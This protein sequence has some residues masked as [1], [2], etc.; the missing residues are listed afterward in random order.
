MSNVSIA[1]DGQRTD[2]LRPALV[3][4]ALGVVFGDI[5]TSPLYAFRESLHAAGGVSHDTVLGLLSLIF[6]AIT[7]V[8]S[9]KY[10]SLVLL[11]DN[12][13][14][15]GILALLAGVL[16]QVPRD[17]R[18]R[19]AAIFAGLAGAAMFYGDSVI[20]PAISVLSAVEG[21]E[22]VSPQFKSLVVPLTLAILVAL[23][24]AQRLGT[25]SM[26]RWFG[27]VM[28][29]W[30]GSLA[31]LGLL[32]IARN[33]QVLQAL[34]P[35][36]AIA[37]AAEN[38]QLMLAVLGAVFLA[39]TGGEALYADLGH[40]GRRPIRLAWF[41]IVMPALALNYFGQGAL[42]LADPKAIENPFFML[43]PE[44]LQLPL[45]VLAAAATVIASQA[46]IS[47]A[48]SLTAQ[49]V[50]LGYIPRVAVRFTSQTSAGQIFVPLV[51]WAL[52]A[53]VIALVLAF[54]SSS[55]LAAAYGIAVSTTMVITTLG[56]M[57][58]AARRWG[59][60]PS[61][62]WLVC[63]PLLVLD[64]AFTVANL[65]KVNDGGW[66]P[67]VFGGVLMLLF[68]TWVRGRELLGAALTRTGLQMQPFLQSLSTY[69]PQ[70]VE[71]TAVFMTPTVDMIPHSL[72]HNLKHNRVLHERVL[73]LTAEAENAPH[74]PPAAMVQLRDLGDGCWYARVRLG[75]QDAH[76]IDAIARNLGRHHDFDLVPAETSFF[77][78]RQ[79]V[80]VS[81]GKG[82]ALWRKRLFGWLMRNALPAS[83]FFHIPPNRVIEIG[84]QVT[85]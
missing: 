34:V 71:G 14:E 25:A 35:L 6:W 83:D 37:F 5:G 8:V 12:D 69:P 20:T 3:L 48:F 59:W 64:V 77:L 38:P 68:V 56:A 13:G 33:P 54:G 42:V 16:R 23:F 60:S 66:F 44:M 50:R 30:F 46:V 40:F 31:L 45:V 67:L 85:L 51:N 24:A 82:M 53:V 17:S 62:V 41:W 29:L 79:T 47:G 70:R 1:D 10:V 36:H 74:V 61:R 19:R 65:T 21:L 4:A 9:L 78:S 28:L 49:A 80:L 2:L 63:G 81:H 57:L 58:I 7:L 18:Y 27:P 55:A 15:G 75:F 26:G 39:V 84:T 73:F 72:L 11:T 52:L 43:A 32:H 22:V 76:D